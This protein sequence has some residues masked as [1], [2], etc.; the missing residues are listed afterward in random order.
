ELRLVEPWLVSGK[1]TASSPVEGTGV[2]T[3]AWQ[4]GRSRLVYIPEQPVSVATLPPTPRI[5]VTGLPETTRAHLLT[6][7]GLLPL[8]GQRAGG[9][10]LVQLPSIAAG[11]WLLLTEDTRTL[12]QVQQ[13]IGRNAMR[14]AQSER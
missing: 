5:V 14:A 12:A 9:G 7:A 11:G 6:P 1:R 13:R 8:A 10:Y 2:E 4:L 3:M